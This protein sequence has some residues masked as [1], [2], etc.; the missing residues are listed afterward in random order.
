MILLMHDLYCTVGTAN[1]LGPPAEARVQVSCERLHLAAQHAKVPLFRCRKRLR[2]APV[3]KTKCCLLTHACASAGGSEHHPGRT[4][5]MSSS[6]RC[7]MPS[8]PVVPRC[9]ATALLAMGKV[10]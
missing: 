1:M 2:V 9:V 8:L 4:H 5:W 7:S 10:G 3:A 6:Y